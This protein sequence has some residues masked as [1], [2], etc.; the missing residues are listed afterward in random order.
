MTKIAY[1]FC[2]T[3]TAHNFR[4]MNYVALVLLTPHM[5]VCLPNC[6]YWL[7]EIKKNENGVASN[8]IMPTLS[9]VKTSKFVQK[10]KGHSDSLT[11]T[12]W[13]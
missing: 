8:G 3:V 10:I 2:R 11:H 7:Y 12:A 13:W 6:Y 1:C 9:F 5:F 4:T